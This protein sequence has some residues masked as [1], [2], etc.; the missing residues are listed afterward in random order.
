[1]Q[2]ARSIDDIVIGKG[3]SRVQMFKGD[4]EYEVQ[5]PGILIPRDALTKRIAVPYEDVEWTENG[6][7]IGGASVQW[8]TLIG[9]G[10]GTAAQPL[11]FYNN[12]NAKLAVGDS[13]TAFADTQTNVQAATNK[14]ANAMDAT[15]PLHTDT[16]GTAGSKSIAFRSTFITTDANFAWNEW[17]LLNGALGGGSTRM[18]NRSAGAG[19]LGTK[20]SAATWVLTATLSLA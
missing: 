1:M 5:G 16:T 9:N 14:L 11:T 15:Y 10:A 6:L 13:S 19:L 7:T 3:V 12:G 2:T 4:I 17:A 20:T 18:L 8:Q